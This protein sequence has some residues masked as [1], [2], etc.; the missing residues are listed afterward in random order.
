VSFINA[1]SLRYT[2]GEG[3]QYSQ[4]TIEIESP[5]YIFL[6]DI[7]N[8]NIKELLFQ[9]GR[10]LLIYQL[11]KE[12]GFIKTNSFQLPDDVC[13]YEMVGKDILYINSQGVNLLTTPFQSGKDWTDKSSLLIKSSS[14]FKGAVF[15]IPLYNKFVHPAKVGGGDKTRDLKDNNQ[16]VIVIPDN[17][18]YRFFIIGSE[19]MSLFLA[20]SQRESFQSQEIEIPMISSI[21]QGNIFE[22]I[23]SETSFPLFVPADLNNDK[24]N[25]F[26]I[27]TNDNICGYLQSCEVVF[28]WLGNLLKIPEEVGQDI[29]L[30]YV[31][32]P[33]IKDINNDG[34]CDIIYTD[35]REGV[36]YIY[37]NQYNREFAPPGRVGFFANTPSQI[38]RTNKWVIEHRLIDLNGDSLQDLVLVGMSKL[39][40]LAGLQAVLAQ[41]LGWEI[42][43]Y[44]AR[45]QPQKDNLF[46]P[47]GADYV[48]SMNLPF[49]FSFTSPFS[50]AKI[51]SIPKI[52]NPYIWSLDGD[53]NNDTF[54][55]LLLSKAKDGS[56]EIYSG[57][58]KEIFKRTSSNSFNLLSVN[59]GF[60]L[61]GMPDGKPI[62]SDINN[63]GKSDIIIPF[64]KSGPSGRN[65]KTYSY[66]IFL[67]R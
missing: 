62:I 51:R 5:D 63:D 22:P 58:K 65:D 7:N 67:S 4:Q 44:L 18:K 14:V 53:F 13:M 35:A 46:Y 66:E 47:K 45:P 24:L 33:L 32:A 57:D 28:K 39:G 11:Q 59:N 64:R 10:E 40:F 42:A 61:V 55:D 30:G 41:T 16:R 52:Y 8:D 49:S 21:Y 17:N 29:A 27:L 12:K 56:F 26:I 25:D 50:S 36:I 60:E 37:L 43:V 6:E 19:H 2:Q 20:G 23:V 38:I 54:K 31:L 1:Q 3:Q 48:R 15:Q 9:K 34:C